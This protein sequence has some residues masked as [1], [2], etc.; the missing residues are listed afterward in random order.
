MSDDFE[1]FGIDFEEIEDAA[2]QL[3]EAYADGYNKAQQD[4]LKEGYRQVVE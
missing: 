3:Q 1:S 2:D 4:M